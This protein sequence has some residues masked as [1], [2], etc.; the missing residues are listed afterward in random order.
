MKLQVLA[1]PVALYTV[2]FDSLVRSEHSYYHRSR[3]C[4][5]SAPQSYKRRF[6]FALSDSHR[7]T[8]P[9]GPIATSGLS[10]CGTTSSICCYATAAAWTSVRGTSNDW[11]LSCRCNTRDS[12]AWY[13]ATIL[14]TIGGQTVRGRASAV[15]IATAAPSIWTI[16]I[17]CSFVKGISAPPIWSRS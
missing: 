7:A 5:F 9:L 14:A 12:A 13:C 17:A 2:R 4:M 8:R 11:F 10:I 3:T 1:R 16:K 15:S 6:K